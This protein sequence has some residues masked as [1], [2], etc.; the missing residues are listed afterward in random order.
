MGAF[1]NI[2][3]L[4]SVS[5]QFGQ[6]GL[7]RADINKDLVLDITDLVL[8]AAAIE[9]AAALYVHPQNVRTEVSDTITA[10][11]VNKWLMDAKNLKTKTKL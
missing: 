7:H 8:V 9:S 1:V 6:S 11:H 4:M 5:T 3:D 10:T 2:L